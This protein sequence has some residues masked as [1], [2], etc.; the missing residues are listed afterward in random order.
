[1]ILSIIPEFKD[2][3]IL[4][5]PP[6]VKLMD[7]KMFN[8]IEVHPFIATNNWDRIDITLGK[9][10]QGG[11]IKQVL[12]KCNVVKVTIP[13]DFVFDYESVMRL[14]EIYTNIASEIRSHYMKKQ[15]MKELLTEVGAT[16]E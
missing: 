5:S 3:I 8:T 10:I 13:K 14:T 12:T 15:D 11:Y 16:F 4:N 2:E 7:Y 9:G 6:N 1:M